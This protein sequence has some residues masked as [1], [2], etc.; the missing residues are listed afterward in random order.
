MLLEGRLCGR[1]LLTE[2]H[3]FLHRLL[4][5]LG[6]C[7]SLRQVWLCL[8][9]YQSD[10]LDLVQYSVP[11]VRAEA[12]LPM[13]SVGLLV[14]KESINEVSLEQMRSYDP[15]ELWRLAGISLEDYMFNGIWSPANF[16]N[17]TPEEMFEAVTESNYRWAAVLLF[18]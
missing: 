17:M 10:Q 5:F 18:F 1:R 12:A 3:H 6:V 7:L 11:L 15:E 4:L 14:E 9:K 16:A 13:L 8:N 2:A